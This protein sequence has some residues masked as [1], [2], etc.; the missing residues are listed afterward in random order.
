MKAARWHARDDIRV[1]TVPDPTPGPDDVVIRVAYCGI[2]G[3]DLEE[4]REGPI[5]VP[6]AEPNPLTGKKAPV[7]MGHEFAG[8]VVAVGRNVRS[9]AIGDRVAPDVVLYCGACYWCRRHQVHLCEHMAALGLAGDGGLAEYCA[10][11]AAM[12]ERAPE[13]VSDAGAAL[14]EPLAVAVRAV[15]RS[16]MALG[17]S[18]AI[19]GAGAVGLLAMQAARAGGAGE[20]FVVERS[21]ARK[22]LAR[23]LGASAVLDP[24]LDDVADEL[25]RVTGG[26]GPDVVIECAG[27]PG[28]WVYATSLVRR[29][30]RVVVIGLNSTPTPINV[31]QA[32][33][34]PEIEV[35]GSLAHVYDEDFRAAVR[36]LGDGR[37]RAEAIISHRIGLDRVVED[38]FLRLETAKAETLKIVVN[39]R[40]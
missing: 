38:G 19:V 36:L 5:W 8:E 14:A 30:G 3:T 10:V 4:Y 18:V 33:V 22:E 13:G 24:T 25:R 7:I 31:T 6:V 27:G 2:C 12:C 37:V 11:P 20:V 29:G 21:P 35:I 26:V 40:G 23:Q 39:L 32:I 17:E 15:R 16:R 1:E 9:F 28:T 34:A